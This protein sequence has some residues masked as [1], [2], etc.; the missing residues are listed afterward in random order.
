[1]S[2]PIVVPTGWAVYCSW[3]CSCWIVLARVA[4]CACPVLAV[5]GTA[6]TGTTV[7][8][9]TALVNVT[10]SFGFFGRVS[11]AGSI[12]L[13]L[14]LVLKH[15]ITKGDCTSVA[16]QLFECLLSLQDCCHSAFALLLLSL[17]Y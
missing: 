10:V 17:D 1:M 3:S 8:V 13:R 9:W 14:L 11:F 5:I 7:F 4:K 16:L 15:V 6:R 12:A 2:K